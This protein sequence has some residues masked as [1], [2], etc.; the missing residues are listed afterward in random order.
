VRAL[1]ERGYRE[2]VL[3]GIHLGAYGK[4]LDPPVPLENLLEDLEASDTPGRLRITS[5][6]PGDFSNGLIDIL[7]RSRKVCSHLHIPVQS[8]SSRILRRMNRDYDRSFLTRLILELHERIPDLAIGADF[9]VGFPGETEDLFQE[10][11]QWVE[12]I[13]FAYLHV[14]PFSRRKGTPAAH[15]SPVVEEEEKKDRS[16]RLR[17]LGKKKRRAF[18]QR[19]LGRRLNV[20]IERREKKDQGWRGLSRNYIPVFIE[21]KDGSERMDWKNQEM[22]VETTGWTEQGLL[23][24]PF[25]PGGGG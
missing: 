19:F 15:Y 6:E 23:G 11:L 3:T 25:D 9:I 20:L 1:K 4:D 24:R 18:N 8:G 16:E 10:T 22:D 5:I 17:S 13:P 7:S 21:D 12:S 14:F 2:V